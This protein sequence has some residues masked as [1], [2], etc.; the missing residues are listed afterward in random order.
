MR[1][2][3]ADD[4]RVTLKLLG[5]YLTKWGH[6]AISCSD[7]LHAWEVLQS[8]ETPRL[9]I[10][11][12][13]MP[14]MHGA[15]LCREVR[16]AG[17]DPY[18]YIILLTSKSSKQ[19]VVTGLEAGA[20]DYLVKPFDP[21]E[22]RVRVRTA[23]RIVELQE[24]LRSALEMAEFRACHDAL[25]H[26]WNR[27]AIL[28]ILERELSRSVRDTTPLAVLI[29]DI[30]HF[31]QVNDE[32]GHVAGDAVLREVASRMTAGVRPYDFVGRYG[33]E[34][35]II[36][37]PGCDEEDAGKAAERLR[38]DIYNSPVHTPEGIIHVSLSF[39]VAT[40]TAPELID[41]DSLIRRADQ[42]LYGAKTSGRNRVRLWTETLPCQSI[43]KSVQRPSSKTLE[44][45]LQLTI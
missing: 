32:H 34:E 44:M 33:G 8:K 38:T 29:C 31:K 11:D 42:A 27:A 5:S 20:D 2:L 15:D 13:V 43:E 16:N 24:G 14:K 7:G 1:I 36:V 41:T 3:I 4:D 10:L 25:T 18:I 17:R 19:D 28:D 9:A 45:A 23:C 35:F 39:G 6:E 12:W 26:V 37:L 40:V 21:N 30:D 22:L